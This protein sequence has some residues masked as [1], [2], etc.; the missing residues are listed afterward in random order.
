MT[1]L[2]RLTLALR[3]ML[4]TQRV[5]ALGSLDPQGHPHV[6]MV[7]FAVDAAQ[8]QLVIHVSRL[9]AHTRH[10][11]EHARVSLLVMQPETPSEPVHA[12]PRLTLDAQAELLSP[13]SPAWVN[14]RAVYLGRFAEAEPMTQ[15]GDFLFVSLSVLRVRQI[16]GFGAARDVALDEFRLAVSEADAA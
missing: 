2:P 14:A 8:A 4:R 12:L 6:S 16:T 15:L 5:A 10:L 13:V 11:Q 1:H 7:P 9:A 3:D